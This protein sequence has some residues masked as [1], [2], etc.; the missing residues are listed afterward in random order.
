MQDYQRLRVW[1]AAHELALDVFG[2]TSRIRRRGRAALLSQMERSAS[3]IGANIAEGCGR[4][5][6][7]DLARFLRI[8]SG[9]AHELE[10]HL[11]LARELGLLGPAD[12][13]R[14]GDATTSVKRMLA[15]LLRRVRDAEA[16][17]DF[18]GRADR[19]AAP[20]VESR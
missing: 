3:S 4:D 5:G 19:G 18:G 2:A 10:Y 15:V 16:A 1:R 12:A 14:L 7:A 20:I 6:Q 13:T 17:P 9:S 8:A 11:L